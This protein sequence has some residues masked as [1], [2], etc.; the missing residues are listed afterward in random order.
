LKLKNK[1]LEEKLES[2]AR[3]V[4]EL[5][6]ENESLNGT[7]DELEERNRELERYIP[8]NS[9]L[10]ISLSAL[11][12]SILNGFVKKVVSNNRDGVAKILG[13]RCADLM[14][15]ARGKT[16]GGSTYPPASP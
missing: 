12:S 10:G 14:G 5:E 1:V 4:E 6:A 9:T 3:Q 16:Q 15:G 7:I 2:T 13:N 8:E 11:G